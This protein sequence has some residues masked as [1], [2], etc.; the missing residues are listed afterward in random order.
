MSTDLFVKPADT[1]QFLNPTSCHPYHCKKGT[2][3]S[4]TLRPNWICSNNSKF[5]KRCKEL[6]IWLLEKVT[7]KKW[8]E[9]RFYRLV[10]V[11]QKV[12]SRR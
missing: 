9:N 3:Y 4:Q 7:V 6:K 2:P 8:Q 11:L 12:Y 5:D 1:Y 10:G